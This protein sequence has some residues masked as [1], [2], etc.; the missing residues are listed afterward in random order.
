MAR[1][2]GPAL[3]WSRGVSTGARLGYG[4]LEFQY[5]YSVLFGGQFIPRASLSRLA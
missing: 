5:A 1:W 4:Y 2:P 3:P